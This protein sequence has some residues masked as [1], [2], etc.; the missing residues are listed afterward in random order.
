MLLR[1]QVL[2]KENLYLQLFDLVLEHEQKLFL[3]HALRAALRS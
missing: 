3:A 1:I 2:E